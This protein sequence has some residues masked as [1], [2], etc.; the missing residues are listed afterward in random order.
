MMMSNLTPK[1]FT[2]RQAT[3]MLPLVK[4][5]AQDIVELAADIEQTRQRLW[6]LGLVSITNQAAEDIYDSELASIREDVQS[7]QG[8]LAQFCEELKELGL[9]I[10]RIQEGYVD[11]PAQRR[12]E[13]IC[14]C[15]KLG[16]LEVRHWHQL[17]ENC[18]SR[19]PLDL[20]LI[21]QSGDHAA[22]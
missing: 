21:R 20:E 9:S 8:R 3:L 16:E 4:S 17:G 6:E 22:L 18:E 5:I 14:L 10:E 1:M 13:P 2:P 7:K 11:F 15:W 12:Q 19:Q